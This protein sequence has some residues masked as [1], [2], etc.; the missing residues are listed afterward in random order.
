[1]FVKEQTGRRQSRSFHSEAN[2]F[3]EE[4]WSDLLNLGQFWKRFLLNIAS[5]NAGK[6]SF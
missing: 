6:D 5:F 2:V 4:L 3:R 1:M